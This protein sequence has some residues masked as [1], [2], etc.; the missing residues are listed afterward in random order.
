MC[1]PLKWKLKEIN[2]ASVGKDMEKRS[3]LSILG[4]RVKRDVLD[5]NLAVAT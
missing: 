5:G 3:L 4:G 1:P 2:I